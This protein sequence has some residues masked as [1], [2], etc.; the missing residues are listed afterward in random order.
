[1]ATRVLKI[2]RN[3]V[4]KDHSDKWGFELIGLVTFVEPPR[5]GALYKADNW[6]YLGLTK[7][8]SMKRDPDT[9]EKVYQEHIKKH[10]F[11]YRYK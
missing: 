2:A 6:D 1:M 8:I 11:A 3:R 7:G 10:I 4:Q 5:S 9:W